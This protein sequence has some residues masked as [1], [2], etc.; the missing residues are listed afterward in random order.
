WRGVCFL[1]HAATFWIRRTLDVNEHFHQVMADGR[2]SR[3]RA[4]LDLKNPGRNPGHAK[5]DLARRDGF[6]VHVDDPL[7]RGGWRCPRL[8]GAAA[9][10]PDECE[11]G[12]N[13]KAQ[14]THRRSPS[15]GR[16][17]LLALPPDITAPTTLVRHCGRPRKIASAA[18]W[19]WARSAPSRRQRAGCSPPC[20]SS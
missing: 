3:K 15:C 16:S 17:V 14:S 11:N 4:V 1:A 7:D 8:S 18:T 10:D 12:T 2:L 9:K 6:V 5:V 19:C 20:A 13:R